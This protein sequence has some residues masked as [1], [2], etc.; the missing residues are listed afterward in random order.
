MPKAT[1]CNVATTRTTGSSPRASRAAAR[2]PLRLGFA[3]LA[4]LYKVPLLLLVGEITQTPMASASGEGV[5]VRPI[6]PLTASIDHRY[7]DGAQLARLVSSI[8]EYLADPLR[9]EPGLQ[10]VP[11]LSALPTTETHAP[12][13]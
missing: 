7:V 8:R 11:A 2:R 10:L 12:S 4:W 9:F 13:S 6:L 5:E 1:W 3:P